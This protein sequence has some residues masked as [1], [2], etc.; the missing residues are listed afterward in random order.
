MI[1]SPWF[2]QIL[3]S[4]FRKNGLYGLFMTQS[5]NRLPFKKLSQPST[6]FSGILFKQLWTKDNL[7]ERISLPLTTRLQIEMPRKT[8]ETITTGSG[9]LLLNSPLMRCPRA[10]LNALIISGFKLLAIPVLHKLR[11]KIMCSSCWKIWKKHI[12]LF[13]QPCCKFVVLGEVVIIW[14]LLELYFLRI[15]KTKN[16]TSVRTRETTCISI[17]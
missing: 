7:T 12:F 6:L 14:Q 5:L 4:I 17:Q 9:S 16:R 13:F 1:T 15:F 8:T 11:K 10:S 2:S 3:I